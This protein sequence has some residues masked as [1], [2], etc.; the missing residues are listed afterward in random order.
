GNAQLIDLTEVGGALATCNL[1]G[2]VTSCSP[3]ALHLLSRM[4]AGF[5]HPPAPLPPSLWKLVSSHDVGEAVQWRP[6]ED[7]ELLLGCHRC[8]LGTDRYLLVMSEISQK[9]N[10][11]SQRLHQQR[12]EALGR[13]VATT[14]HD[15]RSPLSSI[16]FNSNVLDA[17][18]DELPPERV[19]EA[20]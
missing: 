2:R 19:R 1:D 5:D 10:L 11:L 13:L 20:A 4:V 18:I 9:Q 16:V 8:A 15:L 12:L 7:E 3:S 6:S 14:A 17:R